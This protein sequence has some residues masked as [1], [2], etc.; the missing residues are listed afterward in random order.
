MATLRT[1]TIIFALMLLASSV[2]ACG[3]S[4]GDP[5]QTATSTTVPPDLLD[6]PPIIDKVIQA[7]ASGDSAQLE[8]LLDFQD[9]PCVLEQIGIG[10]PP[11]CL[12]GES[13]GTPVETFLFLQCEGANVR[14]SEIETGLANVVGA[15]HR[16][17]AVYEYDEDTFGAGAQYFMTLQ[18]LEPYAYAFITSETGVIAIHFGCGW[19]PEDFVE[20]NDLGSPLLSF[21][22]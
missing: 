18:P 16:P 21:P 1:L 14:R 15:D 9:V 8:A 22:P 12:A 3:G 10:A 17:I 2:G 4:E 13:E 11:L 6:V 19:S 5:E 7:V 20:I